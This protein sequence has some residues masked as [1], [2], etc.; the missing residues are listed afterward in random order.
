MC[1]QEPGAFTGLG[2][3]WAVTETKS[4]PSCC[5]HSREKQP[6]TSNNRSLLRSQHFRGSPSHTV[7]WPAR[8]KGNGFAP[9]SHLLGF[10]FVSSAPATL[11][12]HFCASGESPF[13]GQGSPASFPAALASFPYNPTWQLMFIEHLLCLGHSF[14][15][16]QC[17]NSFILMT[18][19]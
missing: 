15:R 1:N 14:R 3:E 9:P 19:F 13:L 12:P 2:E 10:P 5:L 6:Q 8:P 4:L 18:T 11:P 16:F 17:T 7:T